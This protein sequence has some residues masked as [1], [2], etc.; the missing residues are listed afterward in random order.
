MITVL[1]CN[2]E[3]V[4]NQFKAAV[5]RTL[6]KLNHAKKKRIIHELKGSDTRLAIKE[7]F[8]K[9]LPNDGWKL[10]AVTLNKQ[11]VRVELQ[12]SVGKK[13]LY[14]YLSRFIIEKVKFHNSLQNVTLVVDRCKNTEEMK[15]FNQYLENHLQAILPLTV[16][17]F[18]HH[19]ASHENP[20]LQAVDMFCWGVARK[21]A[22]ADEEWYEKFKAWIEFETTYLP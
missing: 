5:R 4:K 20:G 7:Y 9:Q 3:A 14:N 13:R 11:R 12:T 15:E 10:F 18:I 8:L 2:N 19:E 1:V 16:N 22:Y 21:V 6:K 17:L